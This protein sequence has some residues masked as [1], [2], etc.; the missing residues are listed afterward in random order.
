MEKHVKFID[1]IPIKIS[2]KIHLDNRKI[3]QQHKMNLKLIGDDSQK[4]SRC[5]DHYKIS[6]I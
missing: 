3:V 6:M 4:Q 2:I 1:Q 5:C